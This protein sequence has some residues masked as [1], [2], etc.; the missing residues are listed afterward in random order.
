MENKTRISQPKSPGKS[1]TN[2]FITFKKIIT[3]KEHGFTLV[4]LII[5]I[6]IVGILA[7]MGITQYSATVEKSRLAEAKVR[8][9]VMRKLAYQYWLENGDLTNIQNADVGADQ[10]CTS[11]SYF[12]YQIGSKA[13][14]WLNLVA[15]RCSN[16]SGGKTPNVSSYYVFYMQ[17]YPGTGQSDW[18]CY[19]SDPYGS[20]CFGYQP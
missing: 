9:G 7:A 19:Y 20:S 11:S 4:E 2:Y 18:H 10:T 6:I 5:V 13:S 8:I 17:Y 1:L 16:G 3:E 15:I 14:T 12:S